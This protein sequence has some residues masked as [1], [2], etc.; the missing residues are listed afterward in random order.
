MIPV[1]MPGGLHRYL[2]GEVEIQVAPTGGDSRLELTELAGWIQTLLNILSELVG[3]AAA[4]GGASTWWP[5][6]K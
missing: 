6:M 4:G 5:R 2:R 3:S 1:A